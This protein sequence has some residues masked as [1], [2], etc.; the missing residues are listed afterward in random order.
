MADNFKKSSYD[1]RDNPGAPLDADEEPA[2]PTPAELIPLVRRLDEVLGE[3]L[4]PSI[5]MGIEVTGEDILE[6]VD[7]AIEEAIQPGHEPFFGDKDQTRK[8]FLEGVYEE[9]IQQPSNIFETIR[10]ADGKEVY[11]PLK[12]KTW[13]ATLLMFRKGLNNTLQESPEEEETEEASPQQTQTNPVDM[14]DTPQISKA[15]EDSMSQINRL[16]GG[17]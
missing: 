1:F 10:R 6:V 11:V 13:Q 2:P 4:T 9:L 14:D 3:Y 7:N 15:P 16:F 12:P 8:V 17:R 5:G